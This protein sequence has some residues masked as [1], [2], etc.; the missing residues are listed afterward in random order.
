MIRTKA[1]RCSTKF[2]PVTTSSSDQDD[3]R[4]SPLPL[5][6]SDFES[7]LEGHEVFNCGVLKDDERND[8]LP[9]EEDE[10]QPL[11]LTLTFDDHDDWVP[12]STD[13]SCLGDGENGTMDFESLAF[14]LDSDEWPSSIS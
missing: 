1:T 4:I 10:G 14:L 11:G 7:K 2:F 13:F 9:A 12:N 8:D 6:V 5:L 3:D